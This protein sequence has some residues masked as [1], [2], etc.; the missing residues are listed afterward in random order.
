MRNFLLALIAFT[1]AM[2]TFVLS[3]RLTT[4]S[5]GLFAVVSKD[6]SETSFSGHTTIEYDGETTLTLPSRGHTLKVEE[7]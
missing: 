1:I 3:R 6:C 7:E 5:H 4:I 2:G